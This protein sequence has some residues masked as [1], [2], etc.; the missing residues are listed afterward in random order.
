[1]EPYGGQSFLCP[2]CEMLSENGQT[3]GQH[4]E[5]THFDLNYYYYAA[6]HGL[7]P[8]LI[9]LLIRGPAIQE[10]HGRKLFVTLRK[11]NAPLGHLTV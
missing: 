7:S 2:L 3:E 11:E 6:Q 4:I 9:V 10:K 1:M 8:C 5:N